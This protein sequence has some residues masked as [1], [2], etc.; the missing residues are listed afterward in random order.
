MFLRFRVSRAGRDWGSFWNAHGRLR[1][2]EQSFLKVEIEGAPLLFR[3]TGKLL[4][5]IPHIR[6]TQRLDGRR[7]NVK[8]QP[9]GLKHMRFRVWGLGFRALSGFL[10]PGLQIPP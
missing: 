3:A 4:G 7:K 9:A 6:L 1:V 10:Y 2:Y 5:G 8:Q